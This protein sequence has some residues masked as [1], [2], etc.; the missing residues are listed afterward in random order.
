MRWSSWQASVL[1]LV[2]FGLFQSLRVSLQAVSYQPGISTNRVA[3]H[4]WVDSQP[5]I[6]GGIDASKAGVIVVHSV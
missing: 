1:F 5:G 4:S 6:G 3:Y 2:R